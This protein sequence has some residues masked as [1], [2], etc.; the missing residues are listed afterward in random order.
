MENPNNIIKLI[1][2]LNK[3]DE[4]LCLVCLPTLSLPDHTQM[5]DTKQHSLC[6]GMW[7]VLNWNIEVSALA[8]IA[9]NHPPV[10]IL[11]LHQQDYKTVGIQNHEDHS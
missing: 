6:S 3:F 4:T 1:L 9:T 8:N 10:P 2:N 7:S 5:L 11:F